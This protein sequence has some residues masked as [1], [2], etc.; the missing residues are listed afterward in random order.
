MSL[1]QALILGL[2]Q[3][4]TEFIPVS[5]SGHLT[6]VPFIVGWDE[7]SLAFDVAVHAGTLA[8]VT[9]VFRDRVGDL[10]RTALH[11]RSATAFEQRLF[12]LIAIGTVPAVIVGIT[13]EGPV[14]SVFERPVLVSFLLGLTGYFLM[15]T[16]TLLEQRDEPGRT[17][18]QIREIDAGVVGVG[19]ALAV[20]PGISRS[21]ATIVAGMRIGLDRVAATRFSF[22]L[23]I[24]ILIGALLAQMPDMVSE[25]FGGGDADAFLVGII[26]SGVS[27]FVAVRW[28]IGVISRRGLRPFGI[29]LMFAMTAGLITA[30]ARG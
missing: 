16:E 28:F 18:S 10:F 26:A 21:G 29:Y 19:Q 15:S 7:P 14:S 4:L 25:G 3:G 6:L 20:L 8:A 24:P 12:K 27:G 30:L 23:S 9:W 22:L 5:S 1:F 13:L 17:E 11:Y 2:V